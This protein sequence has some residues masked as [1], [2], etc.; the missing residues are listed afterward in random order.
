MKINEKLEVPEDDISS[1]IAYHEVNDEDDAEE[2]R[3]SIIWTSKKLLKRVS[4]DLTQD[5]ATYRCVN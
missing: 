4:A 1:Y 5:D 3:F 2:P